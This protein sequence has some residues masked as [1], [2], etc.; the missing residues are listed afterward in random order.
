MPELPDLLDAAARE[1][2]PSSPPDFADVLRRARRHRTRRT[3][4]ATLLLLALGAAGLGGVLA[5]PAPDRTAAGPA[6]PCLTR[7]PAGPRDVLAAIPRQGTRHLTLTVGDS[8]TV[9]WST[10]GETGDLVIV[11]DDPKHPLL[12]APGSGLRVPVTAVPSAR[13]EAFGRGEVL[14]RGTGSRGSAGALAVTIDDAVEPAGVSRPS[15]YPGAGSDGADDVCEVQGAVDGSGR[16]TRTVTLGGGS[17]VLE[18]AGGRASRSTAE[19]ALARYRSEH[20]YAASGQHPRAVFG[21]LTDPTG[22]PFP[23][24]LPVWLVVSC[25]APEAVSRGGVRPGPTPAPGTPPSPGGRTLGEDFLPY[26]ETGH[27]LYEEQ[28]GY[29]DQAL[30]SEL[31][32]EVPFARSAGDSADGRKVAITYRADDSCAAF[33]HLDVQEPDATQDVHVRVWLHLLPGVRHC[34]GTRDRH[35]AV[36]GLSY[37]LAG[38]ELVRG[39]TRP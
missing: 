26:D 38:R 39:G 31:L 22:S 25:D 11:P 29:P 16:L 37:P 15:P 21:L 24:R 36:V 14:L 7:D 2:S 10:C 3:A 4:G 17:A 9:G 5:G 18:P 12:A 6:R 20:P 32:V 19:Q 33:D 27:A 1:L 13:F 34:P 35:V 28:T 23:K 8:L 30:R